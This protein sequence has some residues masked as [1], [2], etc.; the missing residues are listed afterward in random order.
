M[1]FLFDLLGFPGLLIG[2][3]I[4]A[5]IGFG[6]SMLAWGEPN[7]GLILTL[8]IVLGITGMIVEHYM[9]DSKK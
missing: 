8:T 1:D 5:G 6:V 7:A 3:V 9:S 4:G 2:L